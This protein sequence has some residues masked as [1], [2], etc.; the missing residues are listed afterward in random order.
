MQPVVEMTDSADSQRKALQ[1]FVVGNDDLAQ[2]ELLAQRFN[3]FEALGVTRDELKHSNFLGFLLDPQANHGLGDRFL[4]RFLQA[5]AESEPGVAPLT[6]I[7]LDLLDLSKSVVERERD[8]IDILVND[9]LNGIRV[10]I[11]NKVD[12]TEHSDQLAKY[13]KRVE[14]RYPG[15]KL[16]GIYLTVNG[17]SPEDE[18]DCKHYIPLSHSTVRELLD[19]LIAS[20]DIRIESDVRFAIDQYREVLGRHFMADQEIKQLCERIY[21]KHKQAI[22]LINENL[23]D[24]RAVARERLLK[25][26]KDS[27][28]ALELDACSTAYVRFI[29][30]VLDLAYFGG[31]WGWTPS[32]RFLLFEFQIRHEAVVLVIQMG[33][34]DAERR[35]QIHQFTRSM[36]PE[37]FQTDSKFYEKWQNLYRKQI[38]D[39]LVDSLDRDEV[40][41]K[42]DEKW[43]EFLTTDLPRIEEAILAHEWPL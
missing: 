16:I 32:G 40:I 8:G 25:L 27:G 20:P 12:S 31:G 24:Q 38:V 37:I 7:D 43:N 42:V 3:I 15:T 19:R 33:P 9:A 10:I 11:E 21:R 28:E 29:P 13:Y 1:A 18:E 35:K 26:I 39:G 22:D 36:T 5:A 6:P 23:P 4:K 41:K 34:G 30:K 17:D 14:A 2:L